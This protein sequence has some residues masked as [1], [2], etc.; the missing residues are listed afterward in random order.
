MIFATLVRAEIGARLRTP[1]FLAAA[2]IM[3]VLASL[4][5][6]L[7]GAPYT[8]ITY[9]N[10]PGLLLG[11][12]A[13]TACGIV[14][15][16]L[17]GLPTLFITG[18]SLARDRRNGFGRL[19]ATLPLSN[20]SIVLSR[21]VA[22]F[23]AS[24]GVAAAVGILLALEG[25]LRSGTAFNAAQ[26]FAHYVPIVVPGLAVFAASATIF[27]ALLPART[28]LRVA[29]CLSGWMAV[30]LLS[31]VPAIGAFD[32][33]GIRPLRDEATR[34]FAGLSGGWSIGFVSVDP[35]ARPL[36]WSGVAINA[37]FLAARLTLL[38]VAAIAVA[39][40]AA[41]FDRFAASAQRAG[42][43]LTALG[44]RMSLPR[45]PALMHS[46]R[47]GIG[48]RI[49]A[50]FRYCAGAQRRLA[51]VAGA[52]AVLA[53]VISPASL[54]AAKITIVFDALFIARLFGI[55]DFGEAR[56]RLLQT[57]PGC[58][59]NWTVWKALD[60]FTTT[61]LL[62]LP[63]LAVDAAREG[64]SSA[65]GLV[66]AVAFVAALCAFCARI[67]GGAVLGT[68]ATFGWWYVCVLNAPP[69]ALDLAAIRAQPPIGTLAA[70]ALTIAILAGSERVVRFR[71]ARNKV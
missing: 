29:V 30:L 63:I 45:P 38:A 31:A 28:G 54:P 5:L 25:T 9:A 1:A 60:V 36:Q 69:A 43:N 2:G 49:I 27:D 71:P 16:M 48:A 61:V 7:P 19:L 53:A 34:A 70:V 41:G 6:P 55:G 37:S 42:N 10:R 8:T 68:V 62:A 17:F 35:A 44:G 12:F 3:L 39:V 4:L 15:T 26:F 57:L 22:A 33:D 59:G 14:L 64:L 13:G 52:I 32:P 56:D 21:A 58:A 40:A 46:L 66:L 24:A 65:A 20:V 50:D 23:V 47:F 11:G 67:S 51:F 18:D